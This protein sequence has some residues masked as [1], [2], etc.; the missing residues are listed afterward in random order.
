[1]SLSTRPARSC[2]FPGPLLGR[3][4]YLSLAN[5]PS[6]PMC[7]FVASDQHVLLHT[8]T[9]AAA[10]ARVTEAQALRWDNL[11]HLEL[12][13]SGNVRIDSDVLATIA[14]YVERHVPLKTFTLDLSTTKLRDA[15][16]TRPSFLIESTGLL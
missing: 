3:D 13:C 9:P 16:A 2:P 15:G 14:D 5:D 12:N 7:I 4:P 8:Q 6:C 11:V 10:S 1:M